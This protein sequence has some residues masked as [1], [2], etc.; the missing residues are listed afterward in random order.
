MTTVSAS[1]SASL[2]QPSVGPRPT[3]SEVARRGDAA[4][5]RAFVEANPDHADGSEA[6][7]RVGDWAQSKSRR[8]IL[9]A[10]HGLTV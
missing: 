3:V 5:L 2:S 9:K 8:S 7:S 10:H 4:E 6:L 1:S